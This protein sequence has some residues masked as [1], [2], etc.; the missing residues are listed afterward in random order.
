MGDFWQ[1][2]VIKTSRAAGLWNYGISSNEKKETHDFL[3]QF[4][5]KN[6]ARNHQLFGEL[7][8]IILMKYPLCS[9]R[10]LKD[11]QNFIFKAARASIQDTFEK[12]SWDG[13]DDRLDRISQPIETIIRR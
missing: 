2:I 1:P 9:A 12:S 13:N 8:N 5:A 11:A 3:K 7:V 10:Y 4:K 6:R